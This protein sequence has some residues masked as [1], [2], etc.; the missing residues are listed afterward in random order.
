MKQLCG[1]E[2]YALG[3]ITGI[4]AALLIGNLGTAAPAT[5]RALE[6]M[7]VATGVGLS[8]IIAALIFGAFVWWILARYAHGKTGL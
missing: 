6:T 1:R 4:L 8:I 5:C 2:K 3:V 7:A